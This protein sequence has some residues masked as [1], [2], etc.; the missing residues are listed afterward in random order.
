[1]EI[2]KADKYISEKLNIKPVTTDRLVD[3]VKVKDFI[4][5]NNL[6]WNPTTKRYDCDGN[7]KVYGNLIKDGKFIIKFGRVKGDF[8]CSHNQLSSLIGAPEYVSGDFNC[9][10]NK[11]E[12][13]EGA[14]QEVV[15]DF[16]CDCNELVS[17]MGAPKSIG[18]D[19]CC[20]NNPKL[21]TLNGAPQTVGGGF[22]CSNCGLKNLVGSPQTVDADFNCKKNKLE[23]LEGAPQTI[24][25]KFDCTENNLESLVGA[26]QT[27]GGDFDCSDNK[28]TS[29]NGAPKI[30][31]KIFACCNNNLTTI[32]DAPPSALNYYYYGNPITEKL[33]IKPVSKERLGSFS[34]EPE[35]DDKTK[36]F[37]KDNNLV[38]NPVTRNYDC[39]GNVKVN[40][41]IV[42]DGRLTIRFGY[43]KRKF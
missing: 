39:N 20:E 11:L 21:T 15:G 24:G 43:V 19:F 2:L 27:V 8:N 17:L 3:W 23:S 31:K 7:V 30:V 37:I 33:N 13:L 40:S 38:W 32:N 16:Y 14:P 36:Q 26:P 6:K 5:K 1:M 28:L 42:E 10:F 9:S 12:T 18:G 25:G 29:L 35:V 22:D 34:K 41:D 4:K